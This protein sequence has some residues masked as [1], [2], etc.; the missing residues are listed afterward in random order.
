MKRGLLFR[1]VLVAVLAV[2]S[3]LLFSYVH[4]RAAQSDDP[5]NECGKRPSNKAKTE[6]ILFEALTNSLLSSR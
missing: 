6:Y 5:A 2:V 3:V 4:A 1:F